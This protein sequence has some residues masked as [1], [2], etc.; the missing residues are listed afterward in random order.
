MSLS[1]FQHVIK[2]LLELGKITIAVEGK[3]RAAKTIIRLVRDAKVALL[4]P[5]HKSKINVPDSIAHT[6][7]EVV[8]GF[9][10]VCRRGFLRRFGGRPDG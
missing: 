4:R 3:G 9:R 10:A 7:A 1:T 6:L 8:G 2:L 5:S